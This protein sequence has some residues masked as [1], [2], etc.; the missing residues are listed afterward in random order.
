[1]RTTVTVDSDVRAMLRKAMRER[2]LSFKEA[3]NQAVRAGLHA[4][5]RTGRR[6]RCRFP[7]YRMGFNRSLR[8]DKALALA[9]AMEDEDILRKMQLGK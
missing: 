1:M 5:P 7:T 6:A 3:L 9:A 2:G 8:W 4:A